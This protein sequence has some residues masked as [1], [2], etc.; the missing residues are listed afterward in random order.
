MEACSSWKPPDSRATPGQRLAAMQRR[1]WDQRNA[2]PCPDAS[3][4]STRG[5]QR[6][7]QIDGRIEG[8]LL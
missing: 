2:H 3:S 8:A 4:Q 5:L 7:S 1:G 6:S